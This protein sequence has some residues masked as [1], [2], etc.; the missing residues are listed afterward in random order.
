MKNSEE[1]MMVIFFVFKQ[2]M[3]TQIWAKTTYELK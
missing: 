1:K 3:V 2:H